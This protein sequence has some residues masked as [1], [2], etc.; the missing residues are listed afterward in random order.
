M[1]IL[2]INNEM[3]ISSACLIED[4]RIIAAGAEE[5][6]SRQ[7]LT[8]AFPVKAIEYCLREAQAAMSD[9]DYV[10]T[11]WNPGV[12]FAKFNPLYS[13]RRRHLIEQLYSVPD[14]L[15]GLYGRQPVDHVYQE[16]HGS[17]GASRIYYLTHHRAHA[18][19]GFFLSPFESAAIFT[20]DAQGEFE[21][22]TFCRGQG[23]KIQHLRSILYPHSLG[24]LYSSFT[25]YLGFQPN[26]DE[27]KVMAMAA[28]AEPQNRYYELMKNEVVL[29]PTDDAFELNLGFF[30]GYLHDQPHLFTPKTIQLFGPAR[31]P[32]DELESRHFAI[33]AAL[34]R[35]SEEAA[36]HLLLWLFRQTG[37]KNLVLSGG[38][39]MNSV[40]NGKVLDLTPFECVF[41]TSCPDD[42]G[43]CL[44]AA[45]YLYN[46]ILDRPRGEPLTHNYFGPH[47]S[48]EEIAQA[49]RQCNLR[50]V[51]SDDICREAARILAAGQIVGWFQGRMEFG[52]RALGNRSIL[53]DPRRP[54]MKDRINAAVKFR[55]AFRPF[56]PAVRQEEQAHF[57][58]MDASGAAPFM[59]KVQRVRADKRALIPAVVHAD[60]SGRVQTVSPETNA[61]FYRLISEFEALTGIP[62]VLN[63]SFNLNGEPIVCSPIDAI[64]TFH[65]CGLDCLVMGNY[66]ITKE[67]HP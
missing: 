35:I 41:I 24:A 63:T 62:I 67:A 17:F 53:A 7:K 64:R 66:L 60:G 59:E 25:D 8:R 45:L 4:G 26:A 37:E 31:Q 11:A 12:Y 9:I 32:D 54:D 48:N 42:S 5:R 15:M 57:F 22:T 51:R 19:N 52:Q 34:Q 28:L 46:H 16:L 61:L 1:K 38:F 40:F 33:A 23:N 21:S 58:E 3:Y 44:G 6:F 56:A 50:A 30:S 14:H 18:A 36:Q 43:N 27:W 2:G 47:Y 39:F 10:A 55:E 29:L 13:G 65:T 49:L 20:A